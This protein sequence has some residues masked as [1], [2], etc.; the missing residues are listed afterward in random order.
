MSFDPGKGVRI[1][2]EV[3]RERYRQED[4]HHNGGEP[5]DCP[6][7]TSFRN[8]WNARMAQNEC[9]MAFEHGEGTWWHI[10]FEEVMEASAE[11]DWPGL[12]KEIIQAI[13]VGFAWVEAGDKRAS[14]N[15]S[16]SLQ[17]GAV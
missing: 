12:R 16:C 1:A 13:A 10:F 15:E 14:A 17:E 4:K 8:A 5:F 7:G 3:F 9:K 2:N 6:D 11:E